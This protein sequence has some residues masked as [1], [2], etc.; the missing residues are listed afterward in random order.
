MD[1]FNIYT[2]TQGLHT[3]TNS[4]FCLRKRINKSTGMPDGS[5]MAQNR[6]VGA[7]PEEQLP[8]VALT[9]SRPLQ[10]HLKIQ[11][12]RPLW[13][14]VTQLRSSDTTGHCWFSCQ[15]F[16]EENLSCYSIPQTFFQ[17]SPSWTGLALFQAHP[18]CVPGKSI[19]LGNAVSHKDAVQVICR[20]WIGTKK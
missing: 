12:F 15:F 4:W 16:H 7:Y 18:W 10:L 3:V 17:P 19:P 9:I 1:T 5:N 6:A 20:T 14:Q 2:P 13:T 8:V 11:C